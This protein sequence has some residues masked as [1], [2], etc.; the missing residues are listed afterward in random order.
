M[1]FA[2]AFVLPPVGL[3]ASIVAAAQSSR[4]RGWVHGFVRAALAISL[5]TTLAAGIGGAYAYKVFDDGQKHAALVAASA[6]FCATVADQPDMIT[7]PTFGF[8]GP[9]ASIPDTVAAIQEYIDRFDALAD[10]S[11]SG[12]R[13]DVARVSE[14][15]GEI[16][17]TIEETR[18][19]DNETNIANMSAVAESTGIVQWADEYCG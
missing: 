15:A 11:P 10:V 6:Q 19:V 8:P 14:V 1:A 9:G 3:I 16:L 18:L 17:A 5:V 13:P 2:L 12:I 4:R 7:P